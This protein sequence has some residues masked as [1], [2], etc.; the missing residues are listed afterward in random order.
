MSRHT[1]GAAVWQGVI[2]GGGQVEQHHGRGKDAGAD[3]E[4]GIT[5]QYR[6]PNQERSCHQR[7]DQ[8]ESVAEAETV[9]AFF[10]ARLHT[11]A[12]CERQTHDMGSN[13]LGFMITLASNNPNEFQ[14]INLQ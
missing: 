2:Q 6:M 14:T 13:R 9:R 5:L 3:D 7:R 11:F 8:P 12:C 1:L 4:P 10:L